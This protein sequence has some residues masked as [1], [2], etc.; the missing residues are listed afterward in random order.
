M[1]RGEQ[2]Q[3]CLNFAKK[4]INDAECIYGL[5]YHDHQ[6]I[7]EIVN[8][9]QPNPSPSIFPDFIFPEGFIEHF[10][11][12]SSKT[13][14]KGATHKREESNFREKVEKENAEFESFCNKNIENEVRS[15]MWIYKNP[16]HR[17]EWLCKSLK[18]TWESHIKSLQ[19]YAGNKEI[20]IFMVEYT[21][22]AMAMHEQIYSE[23]INGR[24]FGD[25]RYPQTLHYYSLCR[26][27]QMLRYLYEF[28]ET[29]QFILFVNSQKCEV[30]KV[31][32]IPAIIEM[33]PWDYV[34]C[35]MPT[36]TIARTY[37]VPYISHDESEREA[38]EKGQ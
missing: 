9:A 25:L 3:K 13:T 6:K 19:N 38:H 15:R 31:D 36:T 20:G 28:R 33:Q 4:Y 37:C 35:P 23:N 2:E 1:S 18:D 32:A 21:E 22:I 26:D 8:S 10:Q 27:K 16:E 17:Y 34:I 5:T 14:K 12:S 30:I 7:I 11:I 24:I 29:I